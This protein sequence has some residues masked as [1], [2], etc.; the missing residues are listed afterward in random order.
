MT[1]LA[2]ARIAIIS[3]QEEVASRDH[4]IRDLQKKLD[5]RVSMTYAAPLRDYVTGTWSTG[6][7][8]RCRSVL[9][10]ATLNA[11]GERGRWAF[12]LLML[13]ALGDPGGAP[14]GG[15]DGRA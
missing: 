5:R 7:G 3:A 13:R 14:G 2:D 9:M 1:A 12:V 15:G 10:L 8:D 6:G 11:A 4:E